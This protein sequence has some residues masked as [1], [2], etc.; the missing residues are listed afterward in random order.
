M[1]DTTPTRQRK[2]KRK[3]TST[4]QHQRQA[5]V[6]PIFGPQVP[7]IRILP[8]P[9]SPRKPNASFSLLPS[10]WKTTTDQGHMETGWC[11]F[12]AIKSHH[13]ADHPLAMISGPTVPPIHTPRWTTAG[14]WSSRKGRVV[15]RQ[16][17]LQSLG[18]LATLSSRERR[19][20]P[21]I[22]CTLWRAKWR[23]PLEEASGG[24]RIST[25]GWFMAGGDDSW[26]IDS[27][28]L[29]SCMLKV[30]LDTQILCHQLNF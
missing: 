22:R 20:L 8:S 15:G 7:I 18:F 28:L 21:A 5:L 16:K 23:G 3:L 27:F 25:P 26:G 4:P 11:R 2:R 10:P 1:S 14:T 24:L 13:P 30:P 19:G 9:K 12:R 17:H 29:S 6:H